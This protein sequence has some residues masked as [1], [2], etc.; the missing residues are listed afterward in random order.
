MG[1]TESRSMR[2]L[3]SLIAKLRSVSQK[4][5]DGACI[6][7]YDHKIKPARLE[8]FALSKEAKK[9]EIPIEFIEMFWKESA[10]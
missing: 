10:G 2:K 5:D 8:I 4:L 3:S 7:T 9:C 6:V 1:E